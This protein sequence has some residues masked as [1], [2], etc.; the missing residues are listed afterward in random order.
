MQCF[1][2]L[3]VDP[4]DDQYTIKMVVYRRGG[5]KDTAPSPE[6]PIYEGVTVYCKSLTEYLLYN[7][8][9]IPLLLDKNYF[10]DLK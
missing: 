2:R 5:Y 10:I 6:A 1:I 3:D 9:V 7:G 8:R 4:A